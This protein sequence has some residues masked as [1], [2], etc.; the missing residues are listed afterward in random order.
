MG[1]GIL[2]AQATRR[3]L[4]P[5]CE[6]SGEE[7]GPSWGSAAG[8][9]QPSGWVPGRGPQK[10]QDGSPPARPACQGCLSVCHELCHGPLPILRLFAFSH[11]R[12][13]SLRRHHDPLR[14][15]STSRVQSHSEQVCRAGGR[16]GPGGPPRSSPLAQDLRMAIAL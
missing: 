13:I 16:P 15:K 10:L 7:L 8:G 9:L 3:R 11:M 14:M 5:R 4:A 2:W 1:L 6:E 12:R